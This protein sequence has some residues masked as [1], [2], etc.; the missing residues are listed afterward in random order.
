MFILQRLYESEINFEVSS[1]CDAGF[2]VRLG[3][4]HCTSCDTY[5][6]TADGRL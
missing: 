2:D 5:N 6:S 1:F 3:V 4:V